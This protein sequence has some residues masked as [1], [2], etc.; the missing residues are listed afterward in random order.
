MMPLKPSPRLNA[1]EP[2][3]SCGWPQCRAACCVYGTWVDAGE[4]EKILGQADLIK[5]HLPRERRDPAR[6]F[7]EETEADAFTP[8]GTVIHTAVLDDREHYGGSAC[9][10]LRGDFRCALQAAGEA[11]GL[12]PWALKP[13]YCI[14]HPLDLDKHGRITLDEVRHMVVEPASCLRPAGQPVALKELFEEELG[15]LTSKT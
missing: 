5:P 10:F 14:L 3:Q 7:G 2:I 8:R 4:R 12:H 11:A 13:F 1:A 6:W 15:Y 9:I